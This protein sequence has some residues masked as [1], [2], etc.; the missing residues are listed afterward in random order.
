MLSKRE[1]I[2]FGDAW[3]SDSSYSKGKD[4]A[5]RLPRRSPGELPESSRLDGQRD[6]SLASNA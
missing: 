1:K 2:C 6:G 5:S 4:D 3:H